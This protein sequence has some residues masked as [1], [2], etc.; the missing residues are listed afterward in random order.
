MTNEELVKLIQGGKR[1]YEIELYNQ[2]LPLIKKIATK[3]SYSI[4]EPLEDLLQQAYFGLIEAVRHFDSGKGC[5]FV[6]YAYHWIKQELRRYVAT[7]GHIIR[8]SEHARYLSYEYNRFEEYVTKHCGRKPTTAEYSWALDVPESA[9]LKLQKAVYDTAVSSLDIPL[10]EDS[11]DTIV[12][13]TADRKQNVEDIVE[14]MHQQEMRDAL[15][16]Q[17]SKM[18]PE[19]AEVILHRMQG[20]SVRQIAE[21]MRLSE[22][23]VHSIDRKA[24]NALRINNK[25]LQ[26]GRETGIITW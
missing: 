18:D 23:E 13:I 26:I 20:H 6:T 25:I 15:H 21:A 1:E 12:D 10:G 19:Q 2:N 17:I 7:C 16:E 8:I 4:T 3:F 14:Q 24:I 5:L 11:E 22:K 9:V